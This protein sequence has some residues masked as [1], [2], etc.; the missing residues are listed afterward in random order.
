MQ[1]L[2]KQIL[3]VFKAWEAGEVK[4]ETAMVRIRQL[5][6]KAKVL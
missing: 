6:K 2:I 4:A 5:L 3:V 1:D